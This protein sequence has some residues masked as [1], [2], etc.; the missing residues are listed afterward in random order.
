[1]LVILIRVGVALSQK[2]M[3]GSTKLG[4]VRLYEGFYKF[5][6]KYAIETLENESLSRVQ[7]KSKSAHPVS[8]RKL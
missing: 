6:R 5:Q 3:P 1:M 4:L 2:V 8:F 7:R